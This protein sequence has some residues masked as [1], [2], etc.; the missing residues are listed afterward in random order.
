[1]AA[2]RFIHDTPLSGIRVAIESDNDIACYRTPSLTN[3]LLQKSLKSSICSPNTP[4]LLL[5]IRY[6]RAIRRGSSDGCPMASK[7][8]GCT[9][10][11]VSPRKASRTLEN[12]RSLNCSAI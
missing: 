6:R 10:N 5:S 4:E 11:L 2:L 3:H 12:L 9:K 1:M 8:P 7:R